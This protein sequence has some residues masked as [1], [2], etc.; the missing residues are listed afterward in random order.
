MV[1]QYMRKQARIYNWEKTV[2]LINCAGK[3]RQLLVKQYH[4]LEHSLTLYVKVK[5]KLF[6]DLTVRRETVKILEENKSR[7]L[8]DI[9]CGYVCVCVCVCV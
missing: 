4:R 9:N 8:F 7:T 5:S 6:T 1:N 2:P 3:P